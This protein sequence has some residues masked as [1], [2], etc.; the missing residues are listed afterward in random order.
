MFLWIDT[1]FFKFTQIFLQYD[2]DSDEEN[3]DQR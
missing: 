3:G 2:R 1:H